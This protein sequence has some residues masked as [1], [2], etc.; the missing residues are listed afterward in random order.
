SGRDGCR[1]N[2]NHPIKVGAEPT[3]GYRAD[4]YDGV[5]SCPKLEPRLNKQLRTSNIPAQHSSFAG[6]ERTRILCGRPTRGRRAVATLHPSCH[7]FSDSLAEIFEGHA[8]A[9]IKFYSGLP[10][11]QGAS[12]SDVGAALLGIIL[13][14]IFVANLAARAGDGDNTLRAL[15]NC[16]LVGV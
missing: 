16:E 5:E 7:I 12:L 2:Q 4:G 14:E 1:E 11:Q 8:Q 9:V 15:Q 13:R 6:T 3:F 10:A